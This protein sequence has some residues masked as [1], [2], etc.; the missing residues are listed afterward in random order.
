VE[1]LG[2][3]TLAWITSTQGI[4]G[5]AASIDRTGCQSRTDVESKARPGLE[6]RLAPRHTVESSTSKI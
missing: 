2:I 5:G 6:G 3:T 1:T 4:Q